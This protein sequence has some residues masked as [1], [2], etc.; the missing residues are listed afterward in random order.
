MWAAPSRLDGRVPQ[1]VRYLPMAPK[2]V[3]R[4]RS[5]PPN[6]RAMAPSPQRIYS[7]INSASGAPNQAEWAA[8]GDGPPWQEVMR[9][10]CAPRKVKQLASRPEV[11]GRGARRSRFRSNHRRQLLLDTRPNRY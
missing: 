2:I 5:D 3:M 10:C 1:V 11:P 9:G 8:C 4:R 6:P 7:G